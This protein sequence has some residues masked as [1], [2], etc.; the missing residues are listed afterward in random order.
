M[1][2]SKQQ[3]LEDILVQHL[4]D[5]DLF[6]PP[7]STVIEIFQWFREY[8]QTIR[9]ALSQPPVGDDEDMAAVGRALMKALFALQ[10]T[11]AARSFNMIFEA[12]K[13][14]LERQE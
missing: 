13:R 9:A 10:V 2:D 14:E 6:N 12:A 11:E 5:E 7:H 1:S 3:A 4:W 8:K